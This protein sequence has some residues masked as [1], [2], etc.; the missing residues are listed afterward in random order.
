MKNYFASFLSLSLIL[1]SCSTPSP[2]STYTP[3]PLIDPFTIPWDDRSIFEKGLVESQQHVLDEL[4][5]ASIYHLEFNIAK[6]LYHLTGKEEVR[7]TN[8]E[9]IPL[10]EVQFHLFPN[11]LG[12]EM[13][14]SNLDVDGTDVPPKFE[15]ENSILIVPFAAP[16]EPNQSTVIKMGF[17][18]TVP[19]SLESN[20]GV[21]AYAE[22]VLALAHAYPMIAVYDD[23]GWNAEIPSQE[24][25]IT[26]GDASFY[27]VRVSA[28]KKLTLVVSGSRIDSSEADQTQTLIAASGPARDFYL[29]ASPHY[30]EVSQKFGEVTIRSYAPKQ[31]QDGA[32]MAMEVASRA[33]QDFSRDYA[34]YPYTEFDI[35]STPTLALGI[36]YPGM[37]AIAERIYDVEGEYRATPLKVYMEATVAHEVGHQWFYNLVGDDQLDDPWLDES[38][39]QFATLQYYKDEYGAGGASGF[40]ASLEDRWARVN[41][42]KIPIGLPVADYKDAE[43]SA[44]VY[45]RGPLFFVALKDAM[46]AE[47]FDQFLT[48]YTK[49]F[50]WGISTPEALQMLAEKHC[51]CDL[52][53]LFQEWVYP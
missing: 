50:S 32:Q 35:V 45:G 31:S 13:E 30:E 47:V 37:V 14:V 26:Y 29:A 2:T 41:K 48:D 1:V 18:V 6:D 24:G 42:A 7:Y 52:D 53:P 9:I 27:I 16:L 23:E 5:A 34:P 51:S 19:Q 3:P 38:L 40:R 10:D 25:D 33:I 20:Y 12:G 8:N 28:P 46:G 11:I 49:T 39:T 4:S 17:A 44:I 15:L 21:L 43:Y 22:D 36:E